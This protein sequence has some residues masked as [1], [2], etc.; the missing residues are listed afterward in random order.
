MRAY[1]MVPLVL[2]SVVAAGTLIFTIFYKTSVIDRPKAIDYDHYYS[3]T[4]KYQIAWKADNKD[5]HFSLQVEAKGWIGE[6]LRPV[7]RALNC[8]QQVA[9]GELRFTRLNSFS[10][11]V[12]EVLFCTT[13]I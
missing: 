9:S 4:Q 8:L 6:L 12:F 7:R 10:K 11:N 1:F 3:L 13:K 2:L 5:I